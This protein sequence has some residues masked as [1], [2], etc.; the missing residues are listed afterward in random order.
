MPPVPTESARSEPETKRISAQKYSDQPNARKPA[1]ALWMRQDLRL[2]DNPAFSAALE[3]SRELAAPLIV[4]FD[5]TSTQGAVP[6]HPIRLAYESEALA[7]ISAV[8]AQNDIRVI[9]S[10]IAQAVPIHGITVLH[11][12]EEWG[13]YLS[14][15]QERQI[16]SHLR[17]QGTL[18]HDHAHSGIIRASRSRNNTSR[19]TGQAKD[20]A[21]GVT[22]PTIV[23]PFHL[24]VPTLIGLSAPTPLRQLR[25]FLED[26]LPNDRYRQLMWRADIGGDVSSRLSIALACGAIAL[27]RVVHETKMRIEKITQNSPYQDVKQKTE[28][29]RQFLARLSWRHGFIQEFET[30]WAWY[31]SFEAIDGAKSA[32]KPVSGPLYGP[33]RDSAEYRDSV[34]RWK[35]GETG[36]PFIDAITKALDTDGWVPFRLR[37]TAASFGVDLLGLDWRDAAMMLGERFADYTPGIHWPQLSLQAGA[38]HPERGPR[39]VNPLKQARELDPD[40]IFVRKWLPELHAI[41]KGFAH[42]AWKHPLWKGRRPIVDVVQAMRA[43]RLRWGAASEAN[44]AKSTSKKSGDLFA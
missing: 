29:Y 14:Y 24:D 18:L 35:N 7:E 36:I 40:E 1:I 41:P 32:Y 31:P 37:Q 33:D 15:S 21:A 38:L 44:P 42:E 43:A 17:T 34:Q 23:P 3:Q 13:D 30:N 16:R 6:P 39:I 2:I 4:I 10:P 12:L 9:S 27:E 19:A 20:Q 11:S 25:D 22:Y 8:L 28:P 26:E 5:R